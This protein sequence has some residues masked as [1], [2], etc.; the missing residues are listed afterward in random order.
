[1]ADTALT[2]SFFLTKKKSITLE[3]M[4]M[5]VEQN[6]PD[7]K[8]WFYDLCM[9][10][11][12]FEKNGKKEKRLSTHLEIKKAFYDRYFAESNVLSKRQKL[13]ADWHME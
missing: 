3:D 10:E 7:D 9:K 8:Q 2:K 13:F 5:Y 4:K 11:K 1:M 12:T 6:N